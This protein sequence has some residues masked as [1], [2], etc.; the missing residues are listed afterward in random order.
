[1]KF[2]MNLPTPYATCNHVI[3]RA[4]DIPNDEG[5]IFPYVESLSR[6]DFETVPSVLQ[7]PLNG[8]FGS[9]HI[10]NGAALNALLPAWRELAIT[11]W[12]WEL[13]HIYT[14]IRLALQTGAGIRTFVTPHGTYAGFILTGSL[15]SVFVDGKCIRPQPFNTLQADFQVATPHT[16]AL[17]ALFDKISFPSDIERG[18]DMALVTSMYDVGVL[19]RK[20]GYNTND[21]EGMARN[22]AKLTF[23]KD[24]YLPINGTNV[25]RVFSVMHTGIGE[26]EI[27]LHH[28]ALFK[29]NRSHRLLSAFGVGCPSFM[30]EGGRKIPLTGDFAFKKNMKVAGGKRAEVKVNTMYAALKDLDSACDDLDMMLKEK[31]VLT[32]AGTPSAAKV[33]ARAMV[34][35]F[36]GVHGTDVLA[37]LR[38]LVGVSVL[39]TPDPSSSK[40][41]KAEEADNEKMTKKAK[42]YMDDF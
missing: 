7:G 34:R 37:A 12:G 42:A 6:D 28:L 13:S 15:F 5:L 36:D 1:M 33:S 35:E 18:R 41:R 16:A 29:V 19:L 17:T 40:K 21:R 23:P 2:N 39:N 11:E 3:S 9:D 4:A 32:F 38:Q 26:S 20:Y 22:A 30:I 24:R 25:A 8:L 14:G 27:P 31:H 10:E